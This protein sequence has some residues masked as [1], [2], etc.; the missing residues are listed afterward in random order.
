[1]AGKEDIVDGVKGIWI[2]WT[3]DDKTPNK[4]LSNTSGGVFCQYPTEYGRGEWTAKTVADARQMACDFA[5][6]VS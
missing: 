4:N 5:S 1:V 3:Y 6:S 2:N